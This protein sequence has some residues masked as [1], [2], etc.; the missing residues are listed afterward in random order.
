LLK[1]KSEV[2]QKFHDFHSL[3]ESLFD[4]NI[5]FVQSDWRGE[6]EKLNSFF[7]KVDI[8]H[9]VSHPHA[10]QQNGS[11]ERKHRHIVEVGLSLLAGAAMPLKFW[12]EV[13]L[14]TTFLINR[15]PSKVIGYQ[16]PLEW[17]IISNQTIP[18]FI[19]AGAHVG[20]I[21]APTIKE[22]LSS[23][24]KNVYSWGIAICTKASSV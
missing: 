8:S 4:R 17:Y 22:S 24:P 16:T 11:A 1:N 20:L 5:I 2:L 14:A 13:F 7:T 6:Y 3:V 21:F 18:L 19:S 9:H 15:T 23:A 12:D 10:H